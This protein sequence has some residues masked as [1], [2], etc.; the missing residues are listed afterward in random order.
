MTANRIELKD[1][2]DKYDRE[3]K[4]QENK[5]GR[6]AIKFYSSLFELSPDCVLAH[7]RYMGPYYIVDCCMNDRIGRAYRLVDCRTGRTLPRLISGDRLE[8]YAAE[9]VELEARLPT[10]MSS[11][12]DD[13]SS[14]QSDPQIDCG[15]ALQEP[16]SGEQQR[17]QT[18]GQNQIRR[19]ITAPGEATN[20]RA[21]NTADITPQNNNSKF[22][23]ALRILAERSRAG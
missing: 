17:R 7:N 5:V 21:S 16:K 14:Q 23:P 11:G 1:S 19:A 2:K 8:K 4:A 3:H 13:V 12:A 10:R 22:Y 6:W 15:Q 9:R 18:D 20:G